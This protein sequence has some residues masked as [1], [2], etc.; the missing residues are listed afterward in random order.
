MI[1]GYVAMTTSVILQFNVKAMINE[2]TTKPTFCKRM[3]ERSTTIVRNKVASLSR[4]DVSMELVLFKSSNHPI[5][6]FKMAVIRA[7]KTVKMRTRVQF[8]N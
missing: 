5:S 3:V 4:R 6:F 1:S 8:L 2:V 7:S